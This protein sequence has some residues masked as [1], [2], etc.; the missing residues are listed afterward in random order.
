MRIAISAEDGGGLDSQVSHHFGRCPYFTLVDLEGEAIQ[1]VE[2]VEN[3]HL[4]S[5]GPG[6]VPAFIQSQGAEVMISGGMGR[7]ALAFFEEYGIKPAT[8][9]SGSVRAAV[10]QYLQGSLSEAGPCRQSVE[11]GHGHGHDH[12]HGHGHGHSEHPHED[13]DTPGSAG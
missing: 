8:G 13:P 3:P 2:V 10:D 6:K 9:A 11:H 12:E 4:S 5:H 7:R 1:G